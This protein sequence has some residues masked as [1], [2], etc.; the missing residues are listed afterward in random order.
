MHS[1]VILYRSPSGAVRAV[2]R[3]GDYLRE[4]ENRDEALAWIEDDGIGLDVPY[5]IVELDEL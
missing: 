1:C 3:I 5:Q 2:I 4:F